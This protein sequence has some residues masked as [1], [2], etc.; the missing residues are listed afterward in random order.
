M[1]VNK[2]KISSPIRQ[3]LVLPSVNIV[4]S[5]PHGGHCLYGRQVSATL[6]GTIFISNQT[7]SQIYS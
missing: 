3:R 7:E 2:H 1:Y 5:N 6:A 4:G